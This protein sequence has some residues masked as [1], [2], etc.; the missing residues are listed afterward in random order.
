MP[1]RVAIVSPEREVWSGDADMVIARTT[2][3]EIGVLPR[4]VPLL[5]V[6]VQGGEVRIKIGNE[7]LTVAVDGGFLSVTDQGV[8]I[9]A[10]HATL[11]TPTT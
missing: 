5:G 1:I 2:E 9:L 6:L 3:G 4:H 8:S 10:E 11:S 7:T